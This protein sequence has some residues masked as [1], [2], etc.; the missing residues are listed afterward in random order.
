MTVYLGRC[1]WLSNP[2]ERGSDIQFLSF[3]NWF[4]I[5]FLLSGVYD[6]L[7]CLPVAFWLITVLPVLDRCLVFMCTALVA[8]L[9]MQLQSKL[10]CLCTDRH[11]WNS[12]GFCLGFFPSFKVWSAAMLLDHWDFNLS[13]VY[14]SLSTHV[15]P[16]RNYSEPEVH[17][18]F[19]S[20]LPLLM[21]QC[22]IYLSAVM[23]GIN[24]KITAKHLI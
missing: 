4:F 8:A 13:S 11:S 22:F 7:L 17:R 3:R 14:S 9:T 6:E 12:P 23:L 21:P 15:F 1:L 5:Q 2:V 18:I 16:P 24:L 20:V 19:R 10:Y